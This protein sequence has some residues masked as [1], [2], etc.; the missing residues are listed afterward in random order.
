MPNNT[1]SNNLDFQD[2]PV[3]C[4][5]DSCGFLFVDAYAGRI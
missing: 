3:A 4:S 5:N 1:E 2:F